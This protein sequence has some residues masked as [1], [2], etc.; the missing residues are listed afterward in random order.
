MGEE[1]RKI[2]CLGF[3]CYME[4]RMTRAWVKNKGENTQKSN[5]NRLKTWI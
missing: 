5:Q 4:G 1:C 2:R 3:K